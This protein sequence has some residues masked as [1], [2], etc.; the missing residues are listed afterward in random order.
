MTKDELDDLEFF[1]KRRQR[2]EKHRKDCQDNG[3]DVDKDPLC[4]LELAERKRIGKSLNEDEVSQE[5]EK[6][7]I[8]RTSLSY[9]RRCKE[10]RGLPKGPEERNDEGTPN[11]SQAAS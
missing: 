1:K 4:F 11:W 7:D 5:E 8:L 10:I 2:L 9:H 3:E 6:A